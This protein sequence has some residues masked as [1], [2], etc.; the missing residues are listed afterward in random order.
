MSAKT[1]P[2]TH[3]TLEMNG[4]EEE[5]ENERRM[6]YRREDIINSVD[7]SRERETE[8]DTER[9]KEDGE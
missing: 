6:Y 1:V 8:E 7:R 2:W 4:D 3:L 9:R 5:G